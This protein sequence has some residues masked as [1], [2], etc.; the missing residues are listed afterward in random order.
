MND[1]VALMMCVQQRNEST[2][3]M[4]KRWGQ[5][6]YT[7]CSRSL[8]AAFCNFI[9][10]LSQITAK[11]KRRVEDWVSNYQRNVSPLSSIC[12][13][14]VFKDVFAELSAKA[15]LANSKRLWFKW[16]HG[17][18]TEEIVSPITNNCHRNLTEKTTMLWKSLIWRKISTLQNFNEN[19]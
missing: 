2:Q 5:N 4:P 7:D 19:P 8:F 13:S 14:I 1:F 6:Q 9:L 16:N 17:E 10:S 15:V 11:I 12:V 3:S 18:T